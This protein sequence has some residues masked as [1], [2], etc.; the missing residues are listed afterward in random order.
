MN[1]PIV[2]I[3]GRPNVGKSTFFNK[4]TGS[5]NKGTGR[6]PGNH[7]RIVFQ[8]EIEGIVRGTL[9]QFFLYIGG[10]GIFRHGKI[11]KNDPVRIV[12]VRSSG[13][14]YIHCGNFTEKLVQFLFCD[15]LLLCDLFPRKN[16]HRSNFPFLCKNDIFT[17]KGKS[18]EY[19]MG[20]ECWMYYEKHRKWLSLRTLLGR[21]LVQ[22]RS[23]P[24]LLTG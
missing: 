11:G 2:A 20:K 21:N 9:L 17:R 19:G 18:K 7:K 8:P 13:C 3:V 22:S 10:N 5:V 12:P 16:D 4:I 1:K 15:L 6:F 14:F 23:L 24:Y